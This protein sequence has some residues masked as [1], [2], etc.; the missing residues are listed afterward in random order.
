MPIRV[1]KNSFGARQHF[2]MGE[3]NFYYYS[4]DAAE[5]SGL[6]DFSK[7]PIV[8]RILLENLLRYESGT[9]DEKTAIKAFGDWISA[10]GPTEK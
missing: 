3:D 4:I 8:L 6:G 10:G 7:L 9:E 2:K 1:G 5:K